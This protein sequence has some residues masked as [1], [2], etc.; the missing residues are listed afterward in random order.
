MEWLTPWYILPAAFALDIMLGD[1]RCLPHPVRWMGKAIERFEAPFRALLGM[2]P[3][4]AECAGWK[5][6]VPGRPGMAVV[7]KRDVFT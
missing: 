4:L 6:A 1:P 3:S 2:Q 7:V 5:P